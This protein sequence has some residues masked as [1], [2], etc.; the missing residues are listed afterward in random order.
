[1]LTISDRRRL[2]GKQIYVLGGQGFLFR[3]VKPVH[4]LRIT[5]FEDH[6]V[7]D[8]CGVDEYGLDLIGVVPKLSCSLEGSGEV[9]GGRVFGLGSDGE[10]IFNR[11][12]GLDKVHLDCWL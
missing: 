3:P 7:Q 4:H 9:S 10:D 11:A 8:R 1:M 2:G 12:D 5:I 6:L